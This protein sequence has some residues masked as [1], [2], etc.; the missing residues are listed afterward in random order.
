MEA[1]RCARRPNS[2]PLHLGGTKSRVT[3]PDIM[4]A[5]H[6]FFFHIY[7]LGLGMVSCQDRG[8]LHFQGSVTD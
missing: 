6:V 5:A 4:L 8:D 2:P 1:C 7:V 3:F